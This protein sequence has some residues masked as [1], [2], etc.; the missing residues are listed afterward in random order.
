[1]AL[2]GLIRLR[3]YPVDRL[4][5][6]REAVSADLQDMARL[7]RMYTEFLLEGKAKSPQKTESNN[8]KLI[9]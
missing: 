4:L 5:I 6:F 9:T 1:M 3:M 7:R 8:K 2:S